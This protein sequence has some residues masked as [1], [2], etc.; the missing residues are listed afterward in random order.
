MRYNGYSNAQ[1][2]EATDLNKVTIIYHVK[3]WNYLGLKSVEDHR[4][5]N[6]PQALSPY[7]VDDSLYV[8][9]YKTYKDFEFIGY[10]W[11]LSLL[12]LYVKQ[13]Y[14][15]DSSITTIKST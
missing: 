14:D 10:N 3:G 2:S 12:V 13:N 1:I 5:R 8:V 15:I 4:G 6:R 9:L 11:T 7:I